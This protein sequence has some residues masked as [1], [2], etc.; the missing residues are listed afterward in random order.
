MY[1][2][3][4]FLIIAVM[5]T[6][7]W[8]ETLIYESDVPTDDWVYE[9]ALEEDS[10]LFIVGYTKMEW[11]KGIQGLAP[12]AAR[13]LPEIDFEEQLPLLVYLGERP[14]GG[15]GVEI[16]SAAVK[17]D[18]LAAV[19]SFRSPQPNEFVTMAFTYP[20]SL[21]LLERAELNNVE[22]VLFVDREGTLLADFR[23]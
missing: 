23:K 2:V 5:L 16:D 21:V 8:G 13:R 20:Y 9:E 14:T 11:D 18:T 22:R 6:L 4:I 15:Y 17:G 19:V 12:Q 1:R 10:M 7:G 3:L